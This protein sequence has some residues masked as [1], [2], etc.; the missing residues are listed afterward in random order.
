[1]SR[2]TRLTSISR[3]LIDKVRNPD[4]SDLIFQIVGGMILIGMLVYCV[5]I[6]TEYVVTI[7]GY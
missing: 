3:T 7:D 2:L 4:T 6:V 5:Y 1:M